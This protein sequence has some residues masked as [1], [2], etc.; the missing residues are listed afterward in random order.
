MKKETET[1]KKTTKAPAK[2]TAAKTVA[3]KEVVKEVTTKKIEK[4]ENIEKSN[5]TDNIKNIA[6]IVMAIIIVIGG[7]FFVS[8]VVSKDKTTTEKKDNTVVDESSLKDNPLLEDGQ[9]LDTNKMKNIHTITWD[10]YMDLYN[11]DKKTVIFIGSATCSWCSYQKPI[12]QDVLY[13]YPEIDVP[14]LDL[15]TVTDDNYSTLLDQTEKPNGIGTP[16]FVTVSNKKVSSFESG[17]RGRSDLVELLE[18]NG[19]IKNND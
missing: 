5:K 2:K 15:T 16:S 3:K 14:Y 12:L 9:V 7:L 1:K 11:G 6:L 19:I 4:K 13:M 18:S 17:A 10:E 8:E